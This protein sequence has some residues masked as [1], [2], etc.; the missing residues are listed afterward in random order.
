MLKDFSIIGDVEGELLK[1]YLLSQNRVFITYR[2]LSNEE[3][4]K[5]I[6]A[7]FNDGLKEKDALKIKECLLFGSLILKKALSDLT[8][9]QELLLEEWHFEHERI[10]NVLLKE[11]SAA[12]IRCIYLFLFVLK[13]L[14]YLTRH[15]YEAMAFAC[16]EYLAFMHTPEAMEKLEHLSKY[17]DTRFSFYANRMLAYS[18]KFLS[19]VY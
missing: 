3:F 17:S 18:P 4:Y 5:Y 13:K 1:A 10:L 7:L 16:I 9:L 6:N 19:S 12:S 2:S 14:S 11:R 15:E 8:L